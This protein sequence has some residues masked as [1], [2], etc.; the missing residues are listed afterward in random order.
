MA[1]NYGYTTVTITVNAKMKLAKKRI[2][3]RIIV[4]K[5]F[6]SEQKFNEIF[7][8]S[9]KVI[10]DIKD[11]KYFFRDGEPD[12]IINFENNDFLL[13]YI[14]KLPPKDVVDRL[15]MKMS[16]FGKPMRQWYKTNLGKIVSPKFKT[17]EELRYLFNFL[18]LYH[19]FNPPDLEDVSR[20]IDS[21]ISSTQKKLKIT[22]IINKKR[23]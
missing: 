11:S 4:E 21:S 3:D 1:K 14:T 15:N 22:N 9:I 13:G 20:I 7:F 19:G 2:L 23:K 18:A 8:S 17:D 6:M 12:G 16:G 5:T 10:K